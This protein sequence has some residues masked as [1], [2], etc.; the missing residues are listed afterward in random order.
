M[1][2]TNLSRTILWVLAG[3]YAVALIANISFG[4]SIPIA[5]VLLVSVAFALIHGAVRY[6]WRGIAAFI[7]ICLVVSNIL[8]NTS[9]LTGFPFGHYHYTDS[10]GPKLFLVPLLIGPAY[11]ANGYLAWVLGNVLIGDVRR[12]ASAFTT[13]AVPFVASFLMVMWDLTFDPRASTIEHMWI[14]QQGGGYFGV[15][16]TNYLGWFF[17]VYVFL[18]LFALVVRFRESGNKTMRTLPRSYYAQAVVM[19][20]VVGLTPVLTFLV[21]GTNS[22]VT[23]AA[24]VVWQTRSIAEAL[25]TVSIYTIIFAAVL[26][27]VRL[28]Q[29]LA[30]AR[31]TSVESAT[32]TETDLLNQPGTRIEPA[33]RSLAG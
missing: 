16:L 24:G 17:T 18:Q 25:A 11:F 2:N 19:Y 6:G 32:A 26:S 30:D 27:A 13:F 7:V 10:L 8:E 3:V 20:A 31:D 5:L 12:G 15:P 21:S 1:T 28:V 22:S 4:L 23:D 33:K 29:G 14:W 9:I